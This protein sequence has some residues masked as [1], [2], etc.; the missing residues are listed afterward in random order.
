[1]KKLFANILGT[2]AALALAW[3]FCVEDPGILDVAIPAILVIVS[4]KTLERLE[5]TNNNA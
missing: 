3:M 4:V 1:M 2:V 5:P